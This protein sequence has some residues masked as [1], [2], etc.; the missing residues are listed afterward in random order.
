MS[1]NSKKRGLDRWSGLPIVSDKKPRV[2]APQSEGRRANR[3][4]RQIKAKTPHPFA[5]T[6]LHITVGTPLGV[7]NNGSS[8]YNKETKSSP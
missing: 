2:D 4:V 5:L 6:P 1:L 3:P 7:D 8:G